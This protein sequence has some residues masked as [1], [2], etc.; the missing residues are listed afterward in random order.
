MKLSVYIVMR[1]EPPKKNSSKEYDAGINYNS[2]KGQIIKLKIMGDKNNKWLKGTIDCGIAKY[3]FA[4]DYNPEL[5][6]DDFIIYDD[7]KGYSA[8]IEEVKVAKNI[9]KLTT[10][11]S[12]NGSSKTEKRR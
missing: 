4:C 12:Q 9:P 5:T 8:G 7:L 1:G 10:T 6:E 11:N 3:I 2:L